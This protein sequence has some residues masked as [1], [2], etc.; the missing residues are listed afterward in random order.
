MSE[1]SSDR[2]LEK[3]LGEILSKILAV[4]DASDSESKEQ[5]QQTPEEQ[6]VQQQKNDALEEEASAALRAFMDNGLFR[7]LPCSVCDACMCAS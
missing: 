5:G 3:V 7:C 2:P 4:E 6:H 1:G